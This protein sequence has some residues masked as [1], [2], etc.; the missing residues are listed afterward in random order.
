VTSVFRLYCENFSKIA[1]F[2]VG[3]GAEDFKTC[4]EKNETSHQAIAVLNSKFGYPVHFSRW[5]Q[6][7]NQNRSVEIIKRLQTNK[8]FAIHLWNKI[9]EGNFESMQSPNIPF[10]QLFSV[11]CPLIYSYIL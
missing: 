3:D 11:H 8:T 1:W 5:E 6:L 10:V 7:L 4:I 2:P 9:T